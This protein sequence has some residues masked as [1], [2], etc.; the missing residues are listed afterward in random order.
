MSHEVNDQIIE[1]LRD[2]V[3][4]L[5]VLPNRPDLENDCL[6]FCFENSE[7]PVHVAMIEFLSRLCSEAMS[8][9]DYEQ[10]HQEALLNA[11]SDEAYKILKQ[12][13]ENNL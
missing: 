4:E 12:R 13:Q 9:Q 7:L 6:D 8:T 2:E 10:M 3:D 5:W 11:R 1:R